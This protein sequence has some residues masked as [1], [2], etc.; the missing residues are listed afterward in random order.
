MKE[1]SAVLYVARYKWPFR[2][3]AVAAVV[4]LAIL[5]PSVSEMWRESGWFFAASTVV[6]YAVVAGAL[7]ET[8]VRQTWLTEEGIH[9]R[10]MFGAVKFVPYPR[11]Q[12]LVIEGDEALIVRYE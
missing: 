2:L 8:F 7:L 1:S 3:V 11:V 4:L 6:A 5:R 10:S 9:Q 12:E